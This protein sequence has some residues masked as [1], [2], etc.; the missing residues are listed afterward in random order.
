M[1]AARRARYAATAGASFGDGDGGV[2]SAC[3]TASAMTEWLLRPDTLAAIGLRADA[4]FVNLDN[5]RGFAY[6]LDADFATTSAA[7]AAAAADPSLRV[8]TYAGDADACGLGT[9]PQE[10]AFVPLFDGALNRTQPWRPWAAAHGQ[11]VLGGYA[12]EWDGGRARPARVQLAISCSRWSG[13]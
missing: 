2:G 6:T 4:A 7:Y 9:L 1:N 12:Y 11:G 3:L 5:G 8:L 10:G 13:D